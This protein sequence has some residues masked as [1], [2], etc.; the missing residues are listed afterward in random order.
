M[1]WIAFLGFFLLFG[2]ATIFVFCAVRRFEE[3]RINKMAEDYG[4]YDP[5]HLLT[6]RNRLFK[7][8]EMDSKEKEERIKAIEMARRSKRHEENK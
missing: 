6:E 1:L 4:V 3:M 5:F 7:D 2:A 8:Q